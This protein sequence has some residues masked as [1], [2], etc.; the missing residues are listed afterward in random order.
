MFPLLDD[1]YFTSWTEWSECS[2][3]CEGVAYKTRTCQV[4]DGEQCNSLIN[5]TIECNT[6]VCPGKWIQVQTFHPFD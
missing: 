3:D 1:S 5:V 6:G 4:D 2:S